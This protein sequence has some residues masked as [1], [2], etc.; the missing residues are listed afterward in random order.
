MK[1]NT[2]TLNAKVL[3]ALFL[4]ALFMG[5]GPGLYLIAPA[6]AHQATGAAG[7]IANG[8]RTV[9]GLPILYAWGLLWFLVEAV[10]L[11]VAYVTIWS[12][13]AEE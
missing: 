5:A 13:D 4:L 11:L 9:F 7:P 1:P 2:P 8:A 10:L 12:R 6:P 3:T